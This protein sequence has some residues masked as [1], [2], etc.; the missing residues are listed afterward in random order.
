MV[1]LCLTNKQLHEI[2]VR[3]LYRIVSLDLGGPTDTK[4]SAFLNPKNIGLPHIRKIRLYLANVMDRCNQQQQAHFAIRMLLEFLPENVLEEFRCD[5]IP[6]DGP[7]YLTDISWCPWAPFSADNLL[8]LYKKQRRMKW[9]EAMTLD[10]EILSTLEKQPYYTE[11]FQ[12]TRKL[13]FYPENRET[14][15][16]CHA[17][18]IKTPKVEDIIIHANFEYASPPIPER[19]LQDSS[20]APGLITSSIFSHMQPFSKCTPLALRDLRLHKINLRYS[21]DT[22]CKIVNFST[23]KILRFFHC[24][25]VDALLAEL[26]KST[27]L[28][29][30]LEC[31][32]L[33]GKDNAENDIL[34]ALDGF[35]CLVSGVKDLVIDLENVKALPSA[36]CIT[37]HAKTLETMNVHASSG[38]SDEEELVFDVVDFALICKDCTRLE[39]MSVAFPV[40][41]LIRTTSDP[42]MAFMN[43]LLDLPSLITLNITT[44]PNNKPSSNWLP[45]NIYEALL[46]NLAQSI[47]THHAASPSIP[48]S[49][50][51]TITTS[52]TPSPSLSPPSTKLALLAFGT[53]DRIYEREDSK[54]QII[55]ARSLAFDAFGRAV[56]AAVSISW[57]LR[58]YVE[59]RSDVLEFVLGRSARPPTRE[60]SRSEDSD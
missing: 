23:V 42:F 50:L 27:K 21:S 18:L 15:D 16:L 4:L 10:K 28:P 19:E 60:Y 13:A 38:D 12:N 17:F 52:S 33:Q 6:Y 59:P 46:Q 34:S 45:R 2:T 44:W 35:L 31:L 22:Y 14:L 53:S 25:G 55:F 11:V 39:Q 56:P 29:E 5:T 7:A 48:A 43:A 40:T 49:P 24:P 57:C 54:N 3:Q 37:R 26:S 20:T 41:S 32:E 30:K 47:F 58:Q 9:L 51:F 36:A 8:L 1:N